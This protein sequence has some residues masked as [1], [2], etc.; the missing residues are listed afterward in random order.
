MVR[1]REKGL[2]GGDAT[3]TPPPVPCRFPNIAL[4]PGLGWIDNPSRNHHLGQGLGIAQ[5]GPHGP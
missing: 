4:V 1:T 3:D 2:L 5:H